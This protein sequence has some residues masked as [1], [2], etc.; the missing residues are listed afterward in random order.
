MSLHIIEI[1]E[2]LPENRTADIRVNVFTSSS[3]RL[4]CLNTSSTLIGRREFYKKVV[5]PNLFIEI[6]Q[7]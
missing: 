5:D 7:D 6:D 2:Y 4:V 3:Y 1:E